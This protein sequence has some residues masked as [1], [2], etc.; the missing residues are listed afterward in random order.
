MK[1]KQIQCKDTLAHICDKLDADLESPRCK[2][3]KEHIDECPDCC[4]YLDSLKKTIHLYRIYPDPEIPD[5]I[6]KKIFSS[7]K[8]PL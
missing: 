3:I 5:G 2:K 8:L 7:L 4:A 6:R 1:I